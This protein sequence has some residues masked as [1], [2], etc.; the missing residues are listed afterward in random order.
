MSNHNFNKYLIEDMGVNFPEVS[1]PRCV[2]VIIPDSSCQ[3]VIRSAIS[4][5]KTNATSG[6]RQKSNLIPRAFE[7]RLGEGRNQWNWVREGTLT[8]SHLERPGKEVDRLTE[9][10]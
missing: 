10:L 5:K 4:S 9:K 8:Q 2:L 7:V 6:I 3:Y 1:A